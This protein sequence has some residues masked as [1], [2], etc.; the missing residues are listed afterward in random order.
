MDAITEVFKQKLHTTDALPSATTQAKRPRGLRRWSDRTGRPKFELA[1][2]AA[3]VLEG[4][5]SLPE[6]GT[7]Q[8]A[9]V[10]SVSATCIN[11]ARRL[12]LEE[13]ADVLLKRRPR[14]SRADRPLRR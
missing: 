14:R 1:I 5:A 2:L 8:I 12:S 10:L 3:E 6:M 13:R 4:R 9:A 11:A 7:A